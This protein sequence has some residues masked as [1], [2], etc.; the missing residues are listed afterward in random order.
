MWR[1]GD[2]FGGRKCLNFLTEVTAGRIIFA[3]GPLSSGFLQGY[4]LALSN[5]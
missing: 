5:L 1:W 2:D 4:K 3:E